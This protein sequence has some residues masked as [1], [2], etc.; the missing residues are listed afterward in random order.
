MPTSRSGTA[1]HKR[2]VRIVK[3]EA[4][5]RGVTHCPGCK[6][7]LDY[8]DGTA[9]NGAQADEIVPFAVTGITSTE[10]SDWQVL[11][12]DC[13]RAKSDKTIAVLPAVRYPHSRDW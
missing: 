12:R 3:A 2:M 4:Q 7:P 9:P 1:T 11:C 10:P 8:T 6:T 13:N 5:N